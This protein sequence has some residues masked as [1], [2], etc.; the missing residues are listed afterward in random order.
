VFICALQEGRCHCEADKVSRSNLKAQGKLRSL[1][2]FK[3]I[4]LPRY[5][6][7][8]F[9][10]HFLFPFEPHCGSKNAALEILQVA[11]NDFMKN[12]KEASYVWR[13]QCN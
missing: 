5:F 10:A 9:L 12:C 8:L 11:R 1:F 7:L 2:I 4:I 13:E 3:C 6:L